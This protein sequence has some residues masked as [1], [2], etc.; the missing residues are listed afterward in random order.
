MLAIIPLNPNISMQGW[1]CKKNLNTGHSSSLK[2]LVRGKIESFLNSDYTVS[3][4]S[5]KKMVDPST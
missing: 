1:Y 3:N 4:N 5:H 2:G